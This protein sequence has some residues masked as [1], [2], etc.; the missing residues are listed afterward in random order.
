MKIVLDTHIVL[1]AA[2][3]QLS[4]ARKEFLEDPDHEIFISA[5]SLWEIA[6]LYELKYIQLGESLENFLTTIE[7]HPR[8]AIVPLTASILA[9]IPVIAAKMHKAPADQII[10][11]TSQKLEAKLMTDD[12]EIRKTDL[13][14][15]I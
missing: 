12:N 10:V 14:K 15:V 13:V 6:K 7:N 1:W 5:I 3:D 4:E 11:A 8:F 9:N 2:S